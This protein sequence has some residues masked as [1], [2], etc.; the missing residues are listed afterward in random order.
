MW[1]ETRY[2][3]LQCSNFQTKTH[4]P[5]LPVAIQSVMPHI[6]IQLSLTLNDSNGPSIQCVVDT[7]AALC[8]GNCHFVAAI[9]KQ[10]SHCVTKIF[11]SEDY[12]PTILLGIVQDDDWAITTD[13]PVAFMFHLPYQGRK[14]NI[15]C[16]C[17]WATSD[18]EHGAWSP[19]DQSHRYGY[20]HS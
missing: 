16:H 8:T 4:C 19:V 15:I 2:L 20:Q 13:L 3:P 17:Y 6:T 5:I 11:L 1:Q 10:Y 12:S 18:H 9:A 7:A 14:P